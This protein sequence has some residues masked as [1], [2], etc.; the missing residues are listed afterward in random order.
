MRREDIRNWTR[1]AAMLLLAAFDAY[2]EERA[3]GRRVVI[4]IPDRKL[5]LID[6]GHLLRIYDV[7]VGKPSTPS[8]QGEF[9]IVN[10]IPN[11]TWYGPSQVVKPGKNNPLGTRWM[12]LSARG[13][14]IHG[15]N[16]PHSI[17]KA[18]SHG[19]IRMR[20]RDL[21]ELFD[22]VDVGVTVELHAERPQLLAIIYAIAIAD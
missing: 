5:L 4:S 7:A 14:G 6:G 15:T 8:P 3:G 11:P 16:A 9:R 13:Y 12:G 21:E 20:Q 2:A 18:A 19:C 1:L 17:G 10:R 22:L